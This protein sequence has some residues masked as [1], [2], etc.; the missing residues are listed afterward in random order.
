MC[1]GDTDVHQSLMK[2]GLCVLC[3]AAMHA[4]LCCR[5]Y[6]P[7][8]GDVYQSFFNSGLLE[9]FIKQGKKYV[10]VSNIDNMGATVDLS[11]LTVQR[12]S[13]TT[14]ISLLLLLL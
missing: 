4:A 11:I 1:P 6:P 10:F 2:S 12:A 7:G 5:W 3:N 13:F 14:Y 8:H 9:E